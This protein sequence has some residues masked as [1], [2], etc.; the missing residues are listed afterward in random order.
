M[1]CTNSLL[2]HLWSNPLWDFPRSQRLL[3]IAKPYCFLS[4]RS[5]RAK[6]CRACRRRWDLFSTPS[7]LRL[8][9]SPMQHDGLRHGGL[10]N[11]PVGT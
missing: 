7:M 3:S 1:F 8:G 5:E 2:R 4:D 9:H 11:R 6:V 10:G